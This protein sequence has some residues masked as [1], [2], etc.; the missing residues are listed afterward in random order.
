MGA[1]TVKKECSADQDP[2]DLVVGVNVIKSR[3]LARI[4]HVQNTLDPDSTS[5]KAQCYLDRCPC[6]HTEPQGGWGGFHR[7]AGMLVFEVL[8]SS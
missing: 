1:G 5:C 4:Y 7:V 3:M 2:S 6:S 8:T